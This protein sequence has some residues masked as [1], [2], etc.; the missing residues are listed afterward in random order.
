MKAALQ[1]QIEE[2]KMKKDQEMM[3]RKQEDLQDEMRVKDEMRR[4]A[5]AEGIPVVHNQPQTFYNQNNNRES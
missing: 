3:R 4:L 5:I 1:Q 2:K